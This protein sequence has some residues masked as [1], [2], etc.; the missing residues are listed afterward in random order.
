MPAPTIHWFRNDL[1]LSDNPALV[2]AAA[3]GPVC[4]VYIHDTTTPPGHGPEG[5]SRLWLERSLKAL[6]DQL[7]GA[8]VVLEGDPELE[9]LRLCSEI[10]ARRVTWT[11]RYDPH[12]V[13]RDTSLKIKL[14]AAGIE[15]IS[16]IGSLLWEPWEVAK[17]DGTPY[18]VFTPFYQK[19]CRAAALPRQPLPAPDLLLFDPA[20][21]D[22]T[23]R[24]AREPWHAGVIEG[25][26]PG[27]SG[28]QAALDHFVS[29]GLRHYLSGRDFPARPD[30]SRLAPHLRFGEISPNQAWYAALREGDTVAQGFQRQLAWREFSS[31]MLFHYPELI[32]S[33]LNPKF[34]DFP[35]RSDEVGFARWTA[36]QTG[37]P[38][39]DAGMRELWQTGYMHNRVRMIVAS[40]LTKNLLI[41][42][43]RG[44][45]W[46]WDTLFDAD[47]ANNT[48]SWQWVA[49][50]G[51]DAAPY[52]RIF[53]PVLQGQKFDPD[54]AYVRKYE[55]EIAGLPD[56]DI[57]APWKASTSTLGEAGVVLGQTYPE[58][59]VD[60]K[61]S[62]D[63]ALAVFEN[64]TIAR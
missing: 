19:G 56:R 51:A 23:V 57:H 27:E 25:W 40:F 1:R 42:W 33:P 50:G 4:P 7:H 45:A 24:L 62:R 5:A 20:N 16:Q 58:P 26:R 63:R 18:R 48:A 3:S 31:H 59:L 2:R 37:V 34:S 13:R 61:E 6:D 14:E 52:F 47:I 10:G 38:I 29:S 32:T 43:K 55:P 53:N 44:A 17:A 8:L 41:D 28:A 64:L 30:V 39:V 21:N 22:A 54:A 9:L 11:R 46:F 15:A 36:G 35:W 60:L 12:G 49:G